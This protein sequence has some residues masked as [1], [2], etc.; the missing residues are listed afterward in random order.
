MIDNL[1]LLAAHGMMAVFL[2]KVLKFENEQARQKRKNP[3]KNQ[4]RKNRGR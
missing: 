1:A 4:T 2:W 3:L